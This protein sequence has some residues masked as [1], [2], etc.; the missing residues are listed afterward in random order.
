[1]A[2]RRARIPGA[3][4]E[5][6]DVTECSQPPPSAEDRD[7]SQAREALLRYPMAS[8]GHR[9]AG[10]Q[11]WSS[12]LLGGSP[13]TSANLT[14]GKLMPK[15]ARFGG[16][17]PPAAVQQQIAP[18]TDLIPANEVAND[19]IS[20]AT[21]AAKGV[22]PVFMR[23]QGKDQLI[24][25]ICTKP[26]RSSQPRH[27]RFHMNSPSVCPKAFPDKIPREGHFYSQ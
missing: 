20:L 24:A 12:V 16:Q 4:F 8:H 5:R 27:R 17:L 13:V 6:D 25:P 14:L 9:W 1:M 19:P 23:Q 22:K 18:A 21:G 26:G 10:P 11:Y 2:P 15:I 3:N 7:R